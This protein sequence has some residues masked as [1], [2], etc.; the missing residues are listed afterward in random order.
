[1]KVRWRKHILGLEERIDNAVQPKSR[2]DQDALRETTGPEPHG[3]GL[4]SAG[5]GDPNPHR[6]AKPL[7]SSWH[8]DHRARRKVHP[9]KA[10]ERSSP[11][12][13]NKAPKNQKF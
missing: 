6:R 12:L 9:G 5:R 8:S 1:M 3:T 7:H 11:D 2:R 4:R 10:E 13:R